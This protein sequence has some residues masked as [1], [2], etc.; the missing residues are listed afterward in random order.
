MDGK[1]KK[2]LF[3][4]IIFGLVTAGLIYWQ[5]NVME[6]GKDKEILVPI[7]VA[8][9]DIASK[10]QVKP[11][12]IEIIKVP[13]EL[14]IDESLSKKEDVVGKYAKVNFIKGQQILLSQ[15][16]GDIKHLPL[17]YGLEPNHRAVTIAVNEVQSVNRAIVPGDRVDIITTYNKGVAAAE[18]DITSTVLQNILVLD[19][20]IKTAAGENASQV[21]T[22]TFSVWPDQA[23]VLVL[24]DEKGSVRLSLREAKDQRFVELPNETPYKT[25]SH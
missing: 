5:L 22:L 25:L 1:T 23:Q 4:S 15:V 6:Q 7:V 8:K 20:D 3:V 17:S 16:T 21:A 10:T 19:N 18:A 13:E 2:L 12:M 14:K 9:E 11:E 24:A